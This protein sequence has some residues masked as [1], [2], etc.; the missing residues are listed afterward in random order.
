MAIVTGALGLVII[1]IAVIMIPRFH[2][3]SLAVSAT[4]TITVSSSHVQDDTPI[5][6][7]IPQPLATIAR[8]PATIAQPLTTIVQPPAIPAGELALLAMTTIDSQ[9]WIPISGAP[10]QI[11]LITGESIIGEVHPMA[12][13]IILVTLAAPVTFFDLAP[14][15]S[16]QHTTL[17]I[18]PNPPTEITRDHLIEMADEVVSGT[19]VVDRYGQLVGQC[20]SAG[21]AEM[22]DFLDPDG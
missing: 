22:V 20:D 2:T 13:D 4:T 5:T 11:Q 3:T 10:V 18:L 21:F 19:P 14:D 6:S 15:L 17:I 7:P 16:R 1:A 8:P 9:P 12:D